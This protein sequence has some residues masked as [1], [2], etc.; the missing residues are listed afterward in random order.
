MRGSVVCGGFGFATGL[1]FGTAVM[2]V[3]PGAV[4]ALWIGMMLCTATMRLALP[5]Y[6]VVGSLGF[7]LGGVVGSSWSSIRWRGAHGETT[8]FTFAE[9]T[10]FVLFLLLSLVIAAAPLVVE[11]LFSWGEL[12]TRGE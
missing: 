7:A 10:A 2:A 8:L 1:M 3:V 12:P 6:A 4:L 9:I 11:K 5:K